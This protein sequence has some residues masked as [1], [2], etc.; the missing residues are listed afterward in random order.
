MFAQKG[1]C[2]LFQSNQ[3]RAYVYSDM[4][5]GSDPSTPKSNLVPQDFSIYLVQWYGIYGVIMTGKRFTDN[6]GLVCRS[7]NQKFQNRMKV[8]ISSYCDEKKLVKVHE[9]NFVKINGYNSDK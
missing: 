6:T 4:I 7:V 2:L 9:Y 8:C 5:G 1:Y 3:G